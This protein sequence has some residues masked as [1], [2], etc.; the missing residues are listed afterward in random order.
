MC[1][2]VYC[3]KP[4]IREWT[5]DKAGYA[6]VRRLGFAIVPEFGGTIHGYCGETLDAILLDLLEWHRRPTM[7]DMHK[8]YVGRSC[9][10]QADHMLLVQP[11]SPHHF[12]QGEMPGPTISWMYCEGR[13]E[14]RRQRKS[15]KRQSTSPTLK[16]MGLKPNG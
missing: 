8:A 11:Y 1:S 14:L 10:R 12:R 3:T 16:M 15:G 13:L 5:R 4:R 2:G 6:K 7:E 9:T